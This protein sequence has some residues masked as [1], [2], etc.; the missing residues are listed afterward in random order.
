MSDIRFNSWY[1]QSGTGG[2]HQDGSGNI[3]IGNTNPS[4]LLDVAGTIK[5][6]T[7]ENVTTAGVITAT[8]G[9]VGD[10]SGLTGVVGSGA[11]TTI[12]DSGTLRGTATSID[13]GTNLDVSTIAAG[14]LTVSVSDAPTF[15]DDVS[16]GAGATTAFFDVSTGR[17]GIGTDNPNAKLQVEYDE[18]NSEIALRLRAYNATTSKTWQISEIN[19]NAGTLSI[20]NATDQ[21]NILNIDGINSVSYTHLRAHET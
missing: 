13:F 21:D 1:H 2:V 4:S 15:T 18:G 7:Y 17:V 19:G 11:G 16:V 5:A 12:F 14:I 6:T 10:G 20:R 8:G 9:F 3:G